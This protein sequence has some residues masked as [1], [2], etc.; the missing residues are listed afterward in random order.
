[1]EVDTPGEPVL[2]KVCTGRKSDIRYVDFD[3]HFS[4]IIEDSAVA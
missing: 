3:E 1:M 4:F 2:H